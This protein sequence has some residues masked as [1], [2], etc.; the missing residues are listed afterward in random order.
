MFINVMEKDALEYTRAIK[1]I[2]RSLFWAKQYGIHIRL[3]PK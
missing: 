2:F 3:V 1:A